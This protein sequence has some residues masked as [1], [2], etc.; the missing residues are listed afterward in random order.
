[1]KTVVGFYFSRRTIIVPWSLIDR[2]HEA[3]LADMR[4]IV[5]AEELANFGKTLHGSKL[6]IR[7]RLMLDSIPG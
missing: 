2:F 6:S 5:A 1:L 4:P 3:Q 7:F